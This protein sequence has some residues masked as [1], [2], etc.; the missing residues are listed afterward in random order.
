MVSL[1]QT[2][3][4]QR[5]NESPMQPL[6]HELRSGEIG[7]FTD[8]VSNASSL[9]L[10]LLIAVKANNKEQVEKFL[11]IFSKRQPSKDSHWIYDNYVLFCLVAAVAK[12]GLDASWISSV[13]NLSLA[14]AGPIDKRIRETFKNLLAGNYNGKN[15][16]H[17]ISM[18]YQFLSKDEHYHD[19]HINGVF[20]DLWLKPF[21]FFNED[22]LDLISLKAIE[23]AVVNKALLSK[24]EQYDLKSFIPAFDSK[25]NKL[26]NVLS[27][28]IIAI[29]ILAVFYGL[30]KLN[31]A[32]ENFPA[33]IKPL[34]FMLGLSGVGVL[35]IIGWKKGIAKIIRKWINS[36]FHYKPM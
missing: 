12:F 16:F 27:W 6:F 21:P 35:G 8:D 34:L 10:N 15:D 9:A 32:E 33:F 5:L 19:E 18:V 26:A 31:A 1:E 36:F 23:V 7:N 2:N 3:F 20:S 25:A 17:Q 28:L 13:I 4:F 30:L 14:G 24:Q 29:L 11:S 22:F